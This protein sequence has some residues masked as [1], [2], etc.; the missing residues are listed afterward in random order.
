M[1]DETPDLADVLLQISVAQS[2]VQAA[3]KAL[4]VAGDNLHRY[5]QQNRPEVIGPPNLGMG[6]NSEVR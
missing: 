3:W 6:K 5:M 4:G 1:S 2:Q